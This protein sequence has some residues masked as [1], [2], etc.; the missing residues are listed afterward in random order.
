M[1]RAWWCSC[2]HMLT[3][4]ARCALPCRQVVLQEEEAAGAG[5]ADGQGLGGTD[6]QGLRGD[7]PVLV[8]YSLRMTLVGCTGRERREQGIPEAVHSTCPGDR[9]WVLLQ[10]CPPAAPVCSVND[11]LP[12]LAALLPSRR[13]Q[14]DDQGRAVIAERAALRG[15]RA[16]SHQRSSREGSTQVGWGAGEGATAGWRQRGGQVAAGAMPYVDLIELPSHWLQ[17]PNNIARMV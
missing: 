1:A 10:P 13:Q 2:A 4:I 11:V 14:P 8:R 12:L 9:A 16:G 6:T 17:H 5:A 7:V 15:E 3:R